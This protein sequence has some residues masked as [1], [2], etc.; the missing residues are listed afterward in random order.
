MRQKLNLSLVGFIFAV[1][2]SASPAM[3]QAI[4]CKKDVAGVEAT[5]CKTPALLQAHHKISALYASILP[6]LGPQNAARLAAAQKTWWND[7]GA[8]CGQAGASKGTD[9]LR[10]GLSLRFN[11]LDTLSLALPARGGVLSD[12]AEAAVLSGV[13][14]AGAF[15]TAD[16]KSVTVPAA[17]I[18]LHTPPSAG[19][20][21]FKPGQMCSLAPKQTPPCLPFG[22]QLFGLQSFRAI[23]K[24]ASALGLTDKSRVY[25]GVFAGKADLT[26]VGDAN[27]LFAA[28]PVC[29]P[30]GKGCQ[31]VYQRWTPVQS[32]AEIGGIGW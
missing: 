18:P 30:K 25:I 27:M 29:G 20:V 22:V 15:K 7:L 21:F 11:H 8:K 14:V 26:L 17:A 24:D 3:A 10:D 13:W 31:M 2:F 23:V 16:G 19:R 6:S 32:G 4:V 5:I 28:F 1:F 9:C 12:D